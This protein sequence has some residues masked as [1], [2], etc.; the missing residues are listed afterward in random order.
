MERETNRKLQIFELLHSTISAGMENIYLESFP[1]AIGT[2][3]FRQYL[4]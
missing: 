3:G 1:E 4:T 2:F